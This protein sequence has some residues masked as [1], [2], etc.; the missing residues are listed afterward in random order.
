MPRAHTAA[1]RGRLFVE[2]EAHQRVGRPSIADPAERRRDLV[3]DS[4]IA[5][6]RRDQRGDR[7]HVA[8][9]P[10]VGDGVQP[11]RRRPQRSSSTIHQS[12]KRS[13]TM[14][15]LEATRAPTGQLAI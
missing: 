7:A 5:I 14:S 13:M 10:Q 15:S 3:P 8:G 4:R 2:E 1:A 6:E 12:M 11:D 9:P